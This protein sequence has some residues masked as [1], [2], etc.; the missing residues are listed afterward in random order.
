[1]STDSNEDIIVVDTADNECA[2][3]QNDNQISTFASSGLE[4]VSEFSVTFPPYRNLCLI[5]S[6]FPNGDKIVSSGTLVSRNVVLSSGHGVYDKDRGGGAKSVIVAVGVYYTSNGTA[7]Y[8]NGSV[9][10]EKLVLHQDWAEKKYDMAD[11]AVITLPENYNS[12]QGYGY[13]TDYTQSTGRNITLIGYPGER[14]CYSNGQI[15][16]TTNNKWNEANRG[17]WTTS[18]KSDYGMSGGSVIDDNTGVVIGI[19]KGHD[20][21]LFGGNV[22]VPLNKT[23][24]DTIQANSK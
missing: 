10:R 15:T 22:C 17:L 9:Q 14:F 2:I 4:P 12:Y 7:V 21:A 3:L 11:W 6:E 18:A 24:T 23:I 19:I 5:W 1:M 20:A 16:G 8:P 13:S